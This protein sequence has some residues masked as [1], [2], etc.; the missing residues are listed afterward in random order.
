MRVAVLLHERLIVGLARIGR[1]ERQMI[2]VIFQCAAQ[3]TV[4]LRFAAHIFDFVQRREH[5][6]ERDIDFD[7]II[8]DDERAVVRDI[9]DGVGADRV[10]TR[11]LVDSIRKIL[12]HIA[13]ILVRMDHTVLHAVL[14]KRPQRVFER[15]VVIDRQHVALLLGLRVRVMRGHERIGGRNQSAASAQGREQQQRKQARYQ[16]A[17]QSSPSLPL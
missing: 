1:V 6:A 13:G 5:V 7:L 3:Q 9:V 8:G 10:L 11:D 16:P 15:F 2:V 17:L 14:H 12:L 4:C